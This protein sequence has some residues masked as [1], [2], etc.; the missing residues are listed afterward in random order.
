[1]VVVPGMTSAPLSVSVPIRGV[2]R[3]LFN[4]REVAHMRDVKGLVKGV[5]LT[6]MVSALFVLGVAGAGFALYSRPFSASLARL[7]LWG[8]GITIGFVLVV[9][10][11]SLL[12][13]DQLFLVFHQLSFSNNL[14]QLDPY[15]DYLIVMFPQGFWFDTSVELR[16]VNFI[17][18]HRIELKRVIGVVLRPRQVPYRS[19]IRRFKC[20]IS[21]DAMPNHALQIIRQMLHK[22]TVAN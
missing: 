2:K 12:G 21:K 1:M 16:D 17:L 5:Y 22:V 9:G 10:L 4:E 8:S 6:A 7:V 18:V 20:H 3:E 19:P 15:Q 11:L 14:W 13:F